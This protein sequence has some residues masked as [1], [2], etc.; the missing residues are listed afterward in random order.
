MLL[1]R[2][3]LSFAQLERALALSWELPSPPF[4]LRPLQNWVRVEV[5]GACRRV[6]KD[7]GSTLMDWKEDWVGKLGGL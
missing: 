6:Q 4:L 1:H 3:A 5:E 2:F 7:E